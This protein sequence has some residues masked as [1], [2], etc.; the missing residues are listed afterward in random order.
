[1]SNTL[2]DQLSAIPVKRLTT[3]LRIDL[4]LRNSDESLDGA[5]SL[6]D[7]WWRE[8]ATSHGLVF[9]KQQSSH[10][11]ANERCRVEA[12]A[13]DGAFAFALEEIEP[14]QTE[15]R[16]WITDVALTS[17]GGS[18]RLGMRLSYRQPH[19]WQ[20]VPEPRA[21]SF[22]RKIV[23]LGNAVDDWPLVSAAHRIGRE[24]FPA[25]RELFYSTRRTLPL[26]VVSE[27]WRT[28]SVYVKEETLAKLLAGA[29][30]VVRLG[31]E[32]SW[33]LSEEVGKD[34]STFQGAVRCYNPQPDIG[35]DKYKHRLWLA[36]AIQRI[37]ASGKDAFLNA[38]VRHV[39][40]Q[41]NANFE[42]EALLTPATL[43]RRLEEVTIPESQPQPSPDPKAD[44]DDLAPSAPGPTTSETNALPSLQEVE[45]ARALQQE[46]TDKL[47][48]LVGRVDQ[49][50][51]SSLMLERDLQEERAAHATTKKNWEDD[52]GKWEE[53]RSLLQ[54]YEQDE[55]RHDKLSRLRIV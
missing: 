3:V 31:A 45:A 41:V 28:D 38:C 29:A 21:P 1:L 51:Q 20:S 50:E 49:L 16:D 2:R 53:D 25:F 33:L 48:R 4:S 17:E 11:L 42:S 46:Q 7:I 43:R 24:E 8:K 44:F 5:H 9:D 34:W 37:D 47:L 35:A 55:N 26:L 30:H 10:S 52:R 27:D 40:T 32:A 6:I 18:A 36:D 39:F 12:R 23:D 22:L 13:Q 14:L 15:P 54:M 19:N